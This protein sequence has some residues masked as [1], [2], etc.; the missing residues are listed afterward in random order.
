[1]AGMIRTRT[2]SFERDEPCSEAIPSRT[3]S[4]SAGNVQDRYCRLR[5]G[6][7]GRFLRLLGEYH[8]VSPY[9]CEQGFQGRRIEGCGDP[10]MLE[11]FLEN[12]AWKLP[13]ES[14]NRMRSITRKSPP[15]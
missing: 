5:V 9:F 8:L 6:N 10:Y 2:P 3:F 13:Y 7:R 11:H 1:M 12:L 14:L 4:L 15:Q